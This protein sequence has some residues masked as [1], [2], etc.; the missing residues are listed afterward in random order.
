M[1]GWKSPTRMVTDMDAML[2]CVFNLCDVRMRIAITCMVPRG[3]F[4]GPP[5]KRSRF[6]GVVLSHQGEV[7][8]GRVKVPRIRTKYGARA[9]SVSG[10]TYSLEFTVAKNISYF[11][12]LL[13]NAFLRSGFSALAPLRP[14]S[15][16]LVT[17]ILISLD[18]SLE[19]DKDGLR[20]RARPSEELGAIEVLLSFIHSFIHLFNYSPKYTSFYKIICKWLYQVERI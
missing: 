3:Y 15:L 7:G 16:P 5:W 10:P 4:T 8:K 2:S 18:S 13:K 19:F 9:F 20:L 14:G 11:R 12:K 17:T 6:L 1:H